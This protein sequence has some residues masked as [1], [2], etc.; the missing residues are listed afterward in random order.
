MPCSAHVAKQLADDSFGL[1]FG[2]NTFLALLFQ[3]ILTISVAS[4]GGFALD[5]QGQF[6]TYGGYFLGLA[7]IYALVAIVQLLLKVS[8]TKTTT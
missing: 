7:V 2:I 8:R 1:I 5:I 6:V 4:E 3:T